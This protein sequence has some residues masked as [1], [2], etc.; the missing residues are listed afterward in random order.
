MV[1]RKSVKNTHLAYIL[2]MANIGILLEITRQA[3]IQTRPVRAR[4]K[5][6]HGARGLQCGSFMHTTKE[7]LFQ[8]VHP[9]FMPITAMQWDIF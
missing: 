5:L 3:Q 8:A 7:R 9:P 4:V 2:P 6:K 1:E